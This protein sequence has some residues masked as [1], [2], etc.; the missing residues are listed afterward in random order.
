MIDL[1]KLHRHEMFHV[2]LWGQLQPAA[3]NKGHPNPSW[4]P[5]VGFPT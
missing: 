3:F 5:S 2:V 1:K 4:E